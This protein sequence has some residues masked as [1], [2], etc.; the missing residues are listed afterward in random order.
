MNLSDKER[1]ICMAIVQCENKHYYD[2]VKYSECPH[3]K[4]A[5]ANGQDPSEFKE[6]KTVAKFVHKKSDDGEMLTQDLRKSDT[7][8]D[9][10]K[11]VGKYFLDKNM[12]PIAGWLVCVSGEN[13]GRSFEIHTG[14]NFVGRSMKMDIH[15]NDE[16][17]SRENHFSIVYD[18][19]EIKF[20]IIQGN[21][22]TYFND[23][24]LAD[25]KDLTED[26]TIEAGGSKYTFVP[27]CKKGRE[28]NE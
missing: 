4:R 10:Q 9:A 13:R 5:K 2:N 17:I 6:N 8:D 26:D 12:N 15:T 7:V 27:F 19:T 23:E 22:I 24:M 16:Q 20:Y 28:W 14:K 3:C 25:A 11:T 18:P 1:D 21:G